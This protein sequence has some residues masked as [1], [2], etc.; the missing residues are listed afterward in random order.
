MGRFCHT[1]RK[2]FPYRVNSSDLSCKLK[3]HS[4]SATFPQNHSR[5]IKVPTEKGGGG[6]HSLDLRVLFQTLQDVHAHVEVE[7][8]LGRLGRA[9]ERV[10]GRGLR[11]RQRQS[12]WALQAFLSR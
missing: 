3:C 11:T 8:V 2:Q 1:K 12:W 4:A 5:Q 7:G 6:G 9:R 10:T